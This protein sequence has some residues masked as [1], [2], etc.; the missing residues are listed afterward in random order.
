MNRFAHDAADLEIFDPAQVFAAGE[1]NHHISNTAYP[2]AHNVTWRPYRTRPESDAVAA[3]FSGIPELTLYSHIPFCETRCY[4]CEYT[5]VGKR[6]LD[7]TREYMDLLGRELAMYR[8]LLGERAVSGFDIGGGTPSFVDAD[9]IAKHVDEV[10]RSFRLLP[11]FEIS[12]ETTPRIAAADPAKLKAYKQCGIDRISM[13][14]QVTEPDLL[15]RLGR[16]EN[17]L[18]HHARARDHIRAAGFKKFNV[19]LMYGFAAQSDESFEALR[20]I[21]CAT[22]LRAFPQRQGVCRLS[23]SDARRTLRNDF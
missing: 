4:F 22:S 13:G 2:I 18:E 19:D 14:L 7:S 20:C 16:S 1:R 12:I 10:M 23:R 15:R 9:L 3:A 5:V 11:G 17:G 21:A 8:D 6:E